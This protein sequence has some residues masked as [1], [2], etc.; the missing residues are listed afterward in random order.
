MSDSRLE[1]EAK[2]QART[3]L[4]THAHAALTAVVCLYFLLGAAHSGGTI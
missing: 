4:L 2:G 3:F 1:K